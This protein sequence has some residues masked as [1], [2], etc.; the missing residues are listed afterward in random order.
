MLVVLGMLCILMGIFFLYKAKRWNSLY[1]ALEKGNL[2][3]FEKTIGTVICDAYKYTTI[4]E[5]RQGGKRNRKKVKV[6]TPIVE[7]EVNGTTYEAQNRE[8]QAEGELP[9]GT[10]MYVWY[11]IDKPNEA[12][13]GTQIRNNSLEAII[14]I[15]WI[16]GGILGIISSIG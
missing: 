7:Y 13:L 10:Q 16:I 8:L 5:H 14:G 15:F 6:V 2:K 9:V 12:I 4:E 3:E 1:T 11:K